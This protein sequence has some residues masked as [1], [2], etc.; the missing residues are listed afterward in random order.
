MGWLVGRAAKIQTLEHFS[1]KGEEWL[2]GSG[3]AL[4]GG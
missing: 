3:L 4:D 2:R 1:E